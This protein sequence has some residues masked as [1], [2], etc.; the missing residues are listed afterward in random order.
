M[1]I[2]QMIIVILWKM[3]LTGLMEPTMSDVVEAVVFGLVLGGLAV[4]F[5]NMW[6]G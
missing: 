4:L 5:T 2:S 1:N 6:F 3:I